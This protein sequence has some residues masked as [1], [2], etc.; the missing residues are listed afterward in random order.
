MIMI[1]RMQFQIIFILS[2]VVR[3][4][5]YAHDTFIHVVVC[6]TLHTYIYI[7]TKIITAKKSAYRKKGIVNFII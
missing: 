7:Y 6:G 5:I 1:E 4:M 2:H 3:L